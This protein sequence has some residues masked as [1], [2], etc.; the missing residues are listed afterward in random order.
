MGINWASW[1]FGTGA[2]ITV[3]W[4]LML[5]LVVKPLV[6]ENKKLAEMLREIYGDKE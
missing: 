4:V 2:G 3:A 5:Y 1:L 6:I